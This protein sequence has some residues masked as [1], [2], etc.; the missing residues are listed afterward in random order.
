MVSR[1]AAVLSVMHGVAKLPLHSYVIWVQLFNFAELCIYADEC[2]NII[3]LWTI[4]TTEQCGG[5]EAKR[6]CKWNCYDW[7][8]SL[9]R[10]WTGHRRFSGFLDTKAPGYFFPPRFVRETIAESILPGGGV[11]KGE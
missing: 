4:R 10:S 8:V 3:A 11:A 7:D 5:P 9:Q 1:V 6:S 2:F